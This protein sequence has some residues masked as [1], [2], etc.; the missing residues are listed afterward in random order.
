MMINLIFFLLKSDLFEFLLPFPSKI[1]PLE[2]FSLTLYFLLLN[3]Q[4]K[5]LL[6]N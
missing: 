4:N 3:S 6:I 1:V 5:R 2:V